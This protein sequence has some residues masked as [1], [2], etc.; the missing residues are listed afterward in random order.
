MEATSRQL[1]DELKPAAQVAKGRYRE[2]FLRSVDWAL[3]LP[4]RDRPQSI[5][6]WR[7][8][9]LSGGG[10]VPLAKTRVLEGRTRIIDD[11]TDYKPPKP[12]PETVPQSTPAKAGMGGAIFAVACLLVVLVGLGVGLDRYAPDLRLNP[13]TYFKSAARTVAGGG[14]SACSTS[15]SAD[16]CWGVIVEK[17]GGVFAR[18]NEPNKE[19][20]ESGALNLCA[21]RVGAGGC[22]VIGVLSKRECWA[23]AEVPS[24]PA[25]WRGASGAT[26]D[27]AKSSAKR[28]CE[29][30]FGFCLVSVTFCADG[31]NRA[32]GTP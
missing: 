14:T 22:K 10:P 11:T 2:V 20:A 19:E 3:E 29:N 8:E 26:I 32:G 12:R 17:N 23:L 6:E 5:S 28:T 7:K 21:Q 25:D 31:S 13:V 27:E 1:K 15:A 30:N 9:L 24:N 16:A 4:P 18:V